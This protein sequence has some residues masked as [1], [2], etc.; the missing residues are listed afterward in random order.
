MRKTACK[1][2]RILTAAQTKQLKDNAYGILAAAR[3]SVL[4]RFPFYGTVAMGLDLIPVRDCRLATMA[5]NGTA[6]YCDIDFLSTLSN[7][8]KVFILAHEVLHNIMLHSMRCEGRDHKL[9]NIATDMEVNDILR[10]DGLSVP[11][12]AVL[13]EKHGF[14]IGLSAED[15]YKRLVEKQKFRSSNSFGETQDGDGE[16]DGSESDASGNSESDASGNKEGKLK[17]QFDKHIYKGTDREDTGP[18]DQQDSYGKVGYDADYDQQLSENAVQRVRESAVAAAQIIERQGGTLPAHLKQLVKELLEP[19]LDWREVLSCFLVKSSGDT[20]RTWNRCN[21]R[22]ISSKLYLPSSYSDTIKVGVVIDT[23]GS[24]AD[25]IKRFMS[26]VNGIVSAFTGYTIDV[27]Q[28]D[29]EVK[30][31]DHY[32]D[33]SPFTPESANLNVLGGGGTRLYP[34]ISYFADNDI[35]V[36]CIVVLTDTECEDMTLDMAPDVPVLWVSTEK[37][38]TYPRIHFGEVIELDTSEA[39]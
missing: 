34:G 24:V 32:D 6:I 18:E 17:G 23:S 9:F 15:Y 16:A 39:A 27:V 35:D 2:A 38:K 1:S 21:R 31:C 22:F 11:H 33:Y 37:R 13:P 20:S 29:T 10:T 12:D 19:K 26:E 36:N 8:D 25:Y 14:A 30:S 7:D 3:K 28:C 5:T 4:D